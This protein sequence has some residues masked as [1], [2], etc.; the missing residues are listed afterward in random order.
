L[1]GKTDDGLPAARG[2]DTLTPDKRGKQ[3]PDLERQMPDILAVIGRL[4]F[5]FAH[6]MPDLPHEY[7][8]RRKAQNDA[9]YVALY[10]AIMERGVIEL[11][12]GKI[13]RY[14]YPGDGW[15]YWSMSARRSN[16]EG[17]HPLEISRHINRHRIEETEKLRAAGL[18][19]DFK[20]E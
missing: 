2:R 13:A 11:W 9:D 19:A 12:K 6:T 3:R 14:L 1:S 4:A 15:R 16:R 20:R 5:Q 7:T 18:I 10:E 8:V 17:R